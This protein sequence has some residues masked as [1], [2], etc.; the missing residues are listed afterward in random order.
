MQT[1]TD[2]LNEL[3]AMAE[4]SYAAFASAL[5]PGSLPFL[6][7]RLPRLRKLAATLTRAYGPNALSLPGYTY[8]EE[9]ML[10]G[11]MVGRLVKTPADWPL[12]TAFLPHICDWSIC[13]SFCSSLKAVSRYPQEFFSVIYALRNDAAPYTA[14]FA[15]V[16]MLRYYLT[17]DSIT[18]VLSHIASCEREEYY[19]QMAAAWTLAEAY[20]KYPEP[21]LETLLMLQKRLSPVAA[22]AVRKITESKKNSPE[23]KARISVQKENPHDIQ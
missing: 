21:T 4:P 13:D 18:P 9:V 5:V 16:M 14:R 23:Q 1:N 11:M 17:D 3:R 19:V 20:A 10:R 7:V 15:L 6:G 12:V 22:M 2:L 8:F